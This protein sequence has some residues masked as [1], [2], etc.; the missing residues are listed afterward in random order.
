MKCPTC[1]SEMEH[2][3]IDTLE[4]SKP[5]IFASHSNLS[6]FP[7]SERGKLI[8]KSEMN[9]RIPGGAYCCKKCNVAYGEFEKF[10]RRYD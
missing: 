9:L 5:G 8:M 1:G 6:W 4:K 3:F 2:G 7:D 10:D